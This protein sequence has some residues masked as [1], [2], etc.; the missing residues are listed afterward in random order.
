MALTL[1]ELRKL[2][3]AELVKRYDRQAARLTESTSLY[4]DELD[5]RALERSARW[6]RILSVVNA[7]FAL[8]A[9]LVA[10]VALI[11]G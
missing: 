2:P 7:I 1:D 9:V 6:S 11:K 8:G 4:R 5:R 3:D 10:G